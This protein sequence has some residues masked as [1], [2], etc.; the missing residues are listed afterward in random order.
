MTHQERFVSLGDIVGPRAQSS[1]AGG[2]AEGCREEESQTLS[3]KSQKQYHS[4][5]EASRP[6][7]KWLPVTHF[8]GVLL[9]PM[10]SPE[11]S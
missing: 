10:T 8:N 3:L 2:L 5:P 1:P 11:A 4:L 7:G 9:V 6:V